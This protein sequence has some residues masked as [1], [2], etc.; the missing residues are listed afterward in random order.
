LFRF[1]QI[2]TEHLQV[3]QAG[4]HAYDRWQVQE[5][6]ERDRRQNGKQKQ[7]DNPACT[8]HQGDPFLA[9]HWTLIWHCKRHNDGRHQEIQ[10][11]RQ[12]QGEEGPEIHHT[13]L[14]DHQCGDI[15]EG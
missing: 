15:A 12:E 2:E 7:T 14:P 5:I 3:T 9:G 8:P 10:H 6:M 4:Q 11:C 13:L 1:L